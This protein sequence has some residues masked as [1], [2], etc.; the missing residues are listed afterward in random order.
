MD[1]NA[2]YII[3][4]DLGT[5]NSTLAY[6]SADEDTPQIHQFSIPQ[7]TAKGTQGEETSLPSFIYLPLDEELETKTVAVD[8]DPERQY[9][10]GV[11]ARV[12]GGELSERLIASP[13][14]W[15]CHSGIDRRESILPITQEDE[16]VKKSPLDS[17]ALILQHLKESWNQQFTDHPFDQQQILITVPASFDPSAR[18]LVQEAAEVA[19]Y[20]EII[21]LEEPQAAF[22]SWL[23]RKEEEWRNEL[24]VGDKVLVVDIGGGT[25]DFSLITVVDHDGDLSLERVA[26][27]SHL[28]LGGDNIDL[29]L[30]YLAKDKLEE[31]GHD[32][33]DWQLTSL[34]YACRDA[35]ERL[36]GGDVDT[37]DVTI[38]GRGSSLIGGTLTTSLSAEEVQ[39]I[40][41]DGF[42][43]S[44][45]ATDRSITDTRTGM[46]QVGLPYAQ[47]AR[48]TAQLAKFLSMT[49]ESD[50]DD[51]EN[52]IHP[53]AVLFNGGTMK[54]SALRQRIVDVLNEW[55]TQAGNEPVKELSDHELDFAVSQ[56]AVYYGIA[57]SGKAIRIKGGTS[58]SY[59][60]GVE[61]AVPT[62]P[63]RETPLKAVCI[64]PFGMEEGTEQVLEG[65]EFSLVLG[66]HAQFR[67]FSHQTP[68][69]LDG[70]EP[71]VGTI[72]KRWKKELTELHPIETALE[73]GDEDAKSIRVN[74]KSRVTELGVLELWCEAADGRKWKLEFDIREEQ[75]ELS[76][77]L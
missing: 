41:L 18:Q 5:T 29:S 43:P 36:L 10:V 49:G 77:T 35:K 58:C 66:E 38:M 30:A 2:K 44:V 25:T 19:E 40:V 17:I 8:W 39:Q 21:L 45:E 75:Q 26:V 52:F 63:G 76:V 9:C 73:K 15:L 33:D 28:L 70:S 47:D 67:F 12:R 23:Q 74:L 6:T 50:S 68:N 46:Q 55:S 54:A 34:Q 64:V 51:M 24:Q 16:E 65:Q 42:M 56:G 37:V 48:I 61:D 22:Y 14:S 60:I 13:K 20:P 69:L 53:T 62:V 27:G 32:I 7:I 1:T 4:I 71:D 59:Y 72:V 11:H 31:E 3:G 57:R